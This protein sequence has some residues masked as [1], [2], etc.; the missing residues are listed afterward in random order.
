MASRFSILDRCAVFGS[1]AD[2][3]DRDWPEANSAERHIVRGQQVIVPQKPE[4]YW[5]DG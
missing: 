4:Q 5:M 3:D 2:L 1:T